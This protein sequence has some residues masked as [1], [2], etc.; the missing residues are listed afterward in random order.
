[1]AKNNGGG[2]A[3]A[4]AKAAAA[5]PAKSS[6]GSFKAAVQSAGSNVSKNEALKIAEQTGKTVA[7]VMAKAVSQGATLGASL[8]NNFNAG[9]L[10][11]NANNLGYFGGAPVGVSRGVN[12]GTYQALSQLQGLQ[13]LRMQPKTVYAGYSTTTTPGQSGSSPSSGSWQTPGTTVYNP[14]VLP[15]GLTAAGQKAPA[16]A[17]AAP[18]A[19]AQGP[20]ANWE[21]SVN[22]SNQELI[23]SINAQI[24]AN[25]EQAQL[26]MGQINELMASMNQTNQANQ[27]GGIAS[28]APYAVT[29]S[30]VAPATGAQ[31]TS[32]VTPR[33]KPT[34]TDLSISPLVADLPGAGLNIGI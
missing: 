8:V 31:T 19:P 26:Y 25:A 11:P 24:K 4:P 15:K 7:Q 16:P 22:N 33:K 27:N 20:V 14:I 30:S 12:A 17:A 29:T 13:G 2:K 28:V 23:D 1:M 18:A 5:A 9:S 3:A 6:G 21:E 34:E 10:G 32:A